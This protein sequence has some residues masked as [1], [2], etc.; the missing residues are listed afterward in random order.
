MKEYT[1]RPTQFAELNELLGQIVSQAKRTLGDNFVGAYLQG[2]FALGDADMFSDCDFLIVTRRT[3][4]PAQEQRIRKLH[5]DIRTQ[6]GH[7]VH[8]L[9]GSYAPQAELRNLSGLGRKWLF[10]DQGHS[11]SEMEWS[12]HCNTEVVRWIIREHGVTLA[13]PSP[14]ELVGEVT[15]EV[16]R[17]KM[18]Q[19]ARDFLSGML[20]WIKLDSPWAQRY[21]VTTLCRI[22]YTLETGQVAS[23]RASLLWARANLDSK[24]QELISE[25]LE[26]RSRG[27]N[28]W[29]PVRPSVLE[30]TLAFNEYAKQRAAG[31]AG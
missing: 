22:L 6:P 25:S 2:S 10:I 11:G 8:H 28:H 19:E 17:A 23:K 21:A 4:T 3:L 5:A 30:A 24:W 27:W 13:G 18:R 26:G 12:T 15:P 7:W 31:H 20:T 1:G 14:R 29:D 16:L 9:E